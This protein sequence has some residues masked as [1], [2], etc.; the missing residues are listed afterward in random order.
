MTA[1]PSQRPSNLIRHAGFTL[2]EMAIVL[3]ILTLLAGGLTVG[4]STQIARRKEAAT[5]ASLEEAR[6]ALLGYL[7]RKGYFPC[8]A[9]TATDGGEDRQG[10][11]CTGSHYSGLLPWAELG[12]QGIDGW[13]HRLR[14]AVAEE[15]AKAI[16]LS[17]TSSP[18]GTLTIKTR[19]SNGTELTLTTNDGAAPVLVLSH[20]AN[21]LGATDQDG[22]TLAAP[23]AGSDEAV[24]AGGDGKV[25]FS[26]PLSENPGASG[27]AF[28]DRVLW[29][30]PYIAVNHL[31]SAGK[32]P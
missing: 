16:T 5:D 21:G 28:D 24:N 18:P 3:L 12:I 29:I 23:P 17:A 6:D 2:V 32:L 27:G 15:Y 14:Y 9:K 11:S 20:G 19:N 1:T 7:V 4:L 31:I 22:N 30:S 10:T 8:P 25:Y 13:G 26:R